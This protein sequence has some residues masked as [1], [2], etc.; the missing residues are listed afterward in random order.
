[1][2]NISFGRERDGNYGDLYFRSIFFLLK[3]AAFDDPSRYQNGGKTL[4]IVKPPIG[5]SKLRSSQHSFKVS[6]KTKMIG[7]NWLLNYIVRGDSQMINL[8]N[9]NKQHARMHT[10]IL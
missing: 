4:S 5:R 1:M 8:V 9:Q 10:A 2:P 3:V 7:Q 6:S